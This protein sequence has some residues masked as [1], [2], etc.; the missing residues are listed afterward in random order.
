[1]TIDSPEIPY[2]SYDVIGEKAGAFLQ[3]IGRVDTLPV[4]IE[5]IVE[6]DLGLHVIP[7]PGLRNVMGMDVFLSS[8]LKEITVDE[9]VFE[10]HLNRFRFSLAHELGHLKLHASIYAASEF[11]HSQEWKDWHAQLAEDDRSRLERQ[12]NVFAGYLLVPIA[13]LRNKFFAL[14]PEAKE[15]IRKYADM[16]SPADEALDYAFIRMADR[17]SPDFQVSSDTLRIQLEREK[18]GKHL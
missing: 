15:K 11:S 12:A 4:D 5:T 16:G 14:L 9:F 1:L 18:L 3:E 13:Q 17:I 6:S 2:L 10:K 7:I 8:N